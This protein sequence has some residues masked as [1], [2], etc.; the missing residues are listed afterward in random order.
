[1][2]ESITISS[3]NTASLVIAR[4]AIGTSVA[5]LVLRGTIIGQIAPPI[6]WQE[7]YGGSHDE[8]GRNLLRTADNG[9]VVSGFTTSVDGDISGQN[10]DHDIE[11]GV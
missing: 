4:V 11:D 3:A 7:T 2:S 5:V 8:M 9:F 1:M 10:G 6:V